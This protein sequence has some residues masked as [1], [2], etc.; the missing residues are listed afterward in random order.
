MCPARLRPDGSEDGLCGRS[1]PVLIEFQCENL[2]EVPLRLLVARLGSPAPEVDPFSV[3]HAVLGHHM[4]SRCQASSPVCCDSAVKGS[5]F[6]SRCSKGHVSAPFSNVRCTE[7]IRSCE[8]CE[9][10]VRGEVAKTSYCVVELIKQ[11]LVYSGAGLYPVT[12]PGG[13]DVA[14]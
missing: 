1:D 13:D 7:H 10:D 3:T 6:T 2:A 14:T 4:L 9:E 5:F 11:V 8:Y 12:V